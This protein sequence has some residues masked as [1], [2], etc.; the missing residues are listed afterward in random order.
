MTFIKFINTFVEDEDFKKTINSLYDVWRKENP[1]FESTITPQQQTT[2]STA[3]TPEQNAAA[4]NAQ[5]SVK[6][7]PIE[8]DLGNMNAKQFADVAAAFDEIEKKKAENE[9]IAVQAQEE[10]DKDLDK[11]QQNINA[12][13][14]GKTDNVVG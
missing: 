13:A 14:N 5:T 2:V 9:K 7:R 12:V 8:G 1:T 11:L 10:I 6:S 4:Q 3:N